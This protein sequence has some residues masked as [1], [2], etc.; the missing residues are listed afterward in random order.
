[1]AVWRAV[2]YQR[3]NNTFNLKWDLI[4]ID[5]IQDTNNVIFLSCGE[6]MM[7]NVLGSI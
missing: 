7:C 3:T 2:F 5:E 6:G 4:E 1:M